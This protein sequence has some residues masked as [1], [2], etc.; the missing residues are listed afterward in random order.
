MTF[1]L[2]END[3]QS[4]VPPGQTQVRPDTPPSNQQTALKAKQIA[5]MKK[6]CLLAF[7][8]L[9]LLGCSR[10]DF[11]NGHSPGEVEEIDNGKVFHLA[12]GVLIKE[13]RN[14]DFVY[15]LIESTVLD[16]ELTEDGLDIEVEGELAGTYSTTPAPQGFV[17][18]WVTEVPGGG[19]GV[20]RYRI[21]EA[22]IAE[23]L[24]NL[25]ATTSI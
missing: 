8:N 12:D 15:F 7:A 3:A 22:A 2:G 17:A 20:T 23:V 5:N 19:F 24:E 4:G 9:F 25:T 14:G 10:T 1:L 16:Y 11:R 21:D 18:A 6:F 13:R